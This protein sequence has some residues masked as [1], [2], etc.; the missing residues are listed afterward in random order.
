MVTTRGALVSREAEATTT[1][2]R[3]GAVAL[4]RQTVKDVAEEVSPAPFV[5]VTSF[6]SAGSVA[7]ASK[8]Y[9]P[10]VSVQPEPRLG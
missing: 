10:P 9:A 7:L 1:A 6:G 3:R 4:V 8:L 2:A 5:A